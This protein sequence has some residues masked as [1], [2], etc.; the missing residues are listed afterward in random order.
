MVDQY[1]ARST[2]ANLALAEKIFAQYNPGYPFEYSFEDENYAKNFKDEQRMDKLSALFAALTVFI[3]C[4]GLFALASYTAENRI[5]EIGIRKVLGASVTGITT[6]LAKDFIVLVL[7]AFLIAA[8]VAWLVMNQWLL[9]YSYHIAIGWDI[10]AA[11]GLLAVLIAVA[12]VS[13]QS[14][15]AAIANPVESLRTE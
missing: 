5:R 3:S 10:F 9:N 13:Y 14:I 7:I 8:P 15:K 2:A 4:L 12:T 11:S 6:L 1:P